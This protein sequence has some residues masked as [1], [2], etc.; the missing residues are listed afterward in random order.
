MRKRRFTVLACTALVLFAVTGG[1]SAADG[2]PRVLPK[3]QVSRQQYD[4]LLAQCRYAGKGG[5]ARQ[6]CEARVAERYR[7]GRANPGLDC[8]RY[9]G[10]TVCGELELTRAERRCVTESVAKGISR[11][12]AEVECFVYR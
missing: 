10:V 12:R 11:R 9:A 5:K 6:R 8:R 3:Q 2:D 4:T 7:V 1:R